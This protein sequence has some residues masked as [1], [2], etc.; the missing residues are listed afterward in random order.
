MCMERG[1]RVLALRDNDGIQERL[2]ELEIAGAQVTT[3][4]IVWYELVL[5]CTLSKVY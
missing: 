5:K 3:Y 4:A 2:T 1:L